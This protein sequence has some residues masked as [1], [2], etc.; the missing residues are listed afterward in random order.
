MKVTLLIGS[1]TGGGAERVVCNLANYLADQG[2]EITVLTV[3]DK[4]TY[5]IKDN[6]RHVVLYGE[7]KSKL[8]H[9]IINVIRLYRMNHYFRKENVDIYITFLP[10]LTK[11]ILAQR[12]FIKCP[13][14]LAE[15]AD[16]GTFCNRSEKN[17]K[18][19]KKYYPHADG[20]IFQTKDARDYYEAQGID[21]KSSVVIPNAI[22]PEFIKPQ[23]KGERRKAIV[24]AG[25]LTKQKNFS[26]L[27]RAFSEVSKQYPEYNLEIYGE[28]PLKGDLINEAQALGIAEKVKFQ[29][30]V[31]NLG[32]RIQDAT[33]FVLSSDF[34]G[35]PNAL[36]EAMA[37][38]LPVISTDCPAGGSKFLIEEKK[39]GLLVPIN[40][41]KK[42]TEAMMEILSDK[43]LRSTMGKNASLV[44]DKLE[45]RKIYGNWENYIR[46]MRR[47]SNGI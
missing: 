41:E 6:V 43:K 19:F 39:N 36:M 28:G 16:P 24:G 40:D 11:F 30:Y 13:I 18:M 34:E 23:Y 26:L 35:M 29:G 10:K 31:K 9:M 27:I 14:I 8:P 32:D 22:N 15:R 21:V 44:C 33:L 45:P 37:L 12:R 47:V 1:L 25:R 3:S 7:S 5:E 17:R 20:Y 42:L 4:Q 38:G 46:K 2:H